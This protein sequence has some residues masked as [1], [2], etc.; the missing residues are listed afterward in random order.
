MLASDRDAADAMT[1]DGICRAAVSRG[2]RVRL[3]LLGDGVCSLDLGV[4]LAAA[5]VEVSLC[6]AD[7][8][9]RGIHK[10]GQPGVFFGSLYDWSRLA[11]DA[12]KVVSFA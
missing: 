2:H 6:E 7:A 5:G 9:M 1:V 8:A 12:D 11:E 10:S 4:N 3:F